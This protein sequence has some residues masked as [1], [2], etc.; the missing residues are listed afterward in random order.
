MREALDPTA[1]PGWIIRH[2][3]HNVLTE[4]AVEFPAGLR[5]WLLGHARLPLGRTWADLAKLAR[6]C[7]VAILAA[8]LRCG[9]FRHT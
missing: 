8:L 6:L 9:P 1:D 4:S 3:G 7:Q 5:Q 2:E